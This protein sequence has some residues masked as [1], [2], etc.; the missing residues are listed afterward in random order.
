MCLL[1]GL[2]YEYYI[3][4]GIFKKLRDRISTFELYL[5]ASRLFIAVNSCSK[6]P[7][8]ESIVE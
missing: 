2:I 6:E 3:I 1:F 7:H 4:V 5:T 8:I